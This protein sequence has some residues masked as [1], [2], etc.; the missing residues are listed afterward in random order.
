[1]F[2]CEYHG[3]PSKRTKVLLT[4]KRGKVVLNANYVINVLYVC[5]YVR[6]YRSLV[7]ECPPSKERPPPTFGPISCNERPPWSEF[8]VA[9]GVHLWSLRS[10]AISAMHIS[11]VRN[12]TLYFTEGYCKAALSRREYL[13]WRALRHTPCL[14]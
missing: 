10:T 2:I 8:H 5:M 9:N 4:N 14:R 3:V 1:M 12:F 6:T 7:K 11:E 13:M